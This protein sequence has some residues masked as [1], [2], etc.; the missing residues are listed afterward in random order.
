MK[1]SLSEHERHRNRLAAVLRDNRTV[2][3]RELFVAVREKACASWKVPQSFEQ[4]KEWR[5]RY[6]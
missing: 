3:S 1:L 4:V 6:S 5:S 2:L